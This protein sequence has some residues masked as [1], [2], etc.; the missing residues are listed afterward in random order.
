[1]VEMAVG[2]SPGVTVLSSTHLPTGAWMSVAEGVVLT[3]GG[4]VFSRWLPVRQE[5]FTKLI[6]VV[7]STGA[8]GL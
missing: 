4:V 6:P 8:F 7:C 2:S 3:R 1:M 5:V